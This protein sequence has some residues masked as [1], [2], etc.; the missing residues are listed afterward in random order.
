MCVCVC[1]CVRSCV[2]ERLSLSMFFGKGERVSVCVGCMFVCVERK[3]KIVVPYNDVFICILIPFFVHSEQVD[4]CKSWQG[5]AHR[6]N[7]M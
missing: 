5:Y 2:S 6:S 4:I 1:K 7:A 3:K